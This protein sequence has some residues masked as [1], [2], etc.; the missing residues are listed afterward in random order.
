MEIGTELPS[1]ISAYTGLNVIRLYMFNV[2]ATLVRPG[3][4][5]RLRHGPPARCDVGPKCG[6][7]PFRVS[8]NAIREPP[9]ATAPLVG[10]GLVLA[11]DGL[12]VHGMDKKHVTCGGEIGARGGTFQR[13]QQDPRIVAVSAVL[14]LLEELAIFGISDAPLQHQELVTVSGFPGFVR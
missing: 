13:Q 1:I 5:P 3:R 7:Q 14:E 10:R 6:S 2:R 11:C 12:G 9:S 4:P 8:R